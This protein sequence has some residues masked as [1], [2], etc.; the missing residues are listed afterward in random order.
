MGGDDFSAY[1]AEAPG[2]YAFVGA[3]GDFPHHHP[4]FVIDERALAIGTRLHV[5]VALKLLGE[6]M[7][8]F[9]ISVD[10]ASSTICGRRLDATRWPDERRTRARHGFAL[11]T[12]GSLPP[13]GATATT[14]ARP[15]TSC[16]ASS[17]SIV[18]GSTPSPTAT[19]RRCCSC[20]AGRRPCGSSPRDPAAARALRGSSCRRCPATGSRSG[21]A[22]SAPASSSARQFH[23]ADGL[24]RPRAATW[25][26][27]ATGARTSPSDWHTP[28]RT[29]CGAAPVHDAAAPLRGLPGVG[30]PA[31]ARAR[32]LAA[33]EG[34]YGHIQGTR[35]QTLAYGLTTR[36]SG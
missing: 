33:E 1:L 35:P 13:T 19:G 4:R 26:R 16:T 20:T 10:E 28:T 5:D 22:A 36:R 24:A 30:E 9:A 32:A 8:P 25:S 6:R 21:P 11:S 23:A 29:R 12:P 34:A 7:R 31:R 18:E 14:G 27:A 17:T 2:C 3:G 15:R